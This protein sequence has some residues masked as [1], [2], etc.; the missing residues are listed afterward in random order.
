MRTD[1]ADPH[2]VGRDAG[3][4][5]DAGHGWDVGSGRDAGHGRDAVS[6]RDAGSGRD[7]GVVALAHRGGAALAPENTVA[8]FQ[9]AV[10]L[11]YRWLE[12]DVRVTRDGVCVAFHDRS[13]RRVTGLAGRLDDLT[14]EQV[15]A[16]RVHGQQPVP[17]LDELLGR[18]PEV[19]WVLD[20]KQPSALSRLVATLRAAGAAQRVCL[21]G[22]WDRWLARA[23]AQLGVPTALGWRALASLLAGRARRPAGAVAAHVP[24]RLAGRR[25]P[26]PA[27][28]ARTHEAGLRLVVWGAD[29]AEEMH[30]LLDEHVDGII[31]D[32]PD[33]LRDV[34]VA[35]DSW[36][37]A[38]GARSSGAPTP[39][40]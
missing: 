33:V 27:L 8:A 16:L 32:R 26:A 17:R 38:L 18:W 35:R 9:R 29:T 19:R 10:G 11:G 31:T 25:I 2:P 24:L 13:L 12:T 4:G 30:R 7:T 21:S 40:G 20:V 34:L 1:R 36:P 3:P 23:A 6:G 37:P 5:W 39:V 15:R 22:T 28:V 14:W